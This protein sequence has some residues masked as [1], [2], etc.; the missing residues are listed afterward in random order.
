MGVG[1]YG[2]ARFGAFEGLAFA[3]VFAFAGLFVFARFFMMRNLQYASHA[4]QTRAPRPRPAVRLTVSVP[5]R[6]VRR[7]QPPP[8]T[9][10]R[11]ARRVLR[12][13]ETPWVWWWRHPWVVV[14]V[15]V[16]LTP[17]AL[18][19]LRLIDDTG[20]ALLI[21]P[22]VVVMAVIFLVLVA[23]AAR[24]SALRSAT[25]AFAGGG[26]AV[27][28]AAL[29]ALPMIHVIGQ[30]SCP[31]RMGPDRGATVTMQLFE[32]WRKGEP[33]P[34]VWSS[35]A[36]ADAW[37]PRADELALLDYKLVDSGCWERLSP[38]ATKKTWHEFRVTV[39][40]A[41]GDPSS[42]MFTVHTLATLAGWKITEI[43]EPHFD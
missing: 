36:G 38:V 12:W 20:V 30:R 43:E 16:F 2:V 37:K 26:S 4:G 41:S 33:A 15:L 23:I 31:E 3:A 9:A 19:S 42:K 11:P 35:A 40:P 17:G 6:Q 25:R 22:L 21:L 1:V 28:A 34:D 7:W 39:Q 10:R 13:W 32:A 18:L 24:S 29:L 14:W 5:P 8:P 27:I